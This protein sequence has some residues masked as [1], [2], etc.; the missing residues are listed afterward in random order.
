MVDSRGN[1]LSSI[2][3]VLLAVSHE[4]EIIARPSGKELS[5]CTS[6]H[7]FAYNQ[8]GEMLLDESSGLFNVN[9]Y[10]KVAEA[11][12]KICSA[13]IAPHGEDD[14]MGNGISIDGPWLRQALEEKAKDANEWRGGT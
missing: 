7:A 11:A 3:A 5:T 6:A 2:T 8:Y 9:L 1:P 14:M 13:T 10:E 12:S 4:D